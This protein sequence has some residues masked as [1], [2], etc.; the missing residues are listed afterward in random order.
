MKARREV[1]EKLV[2]SAVAKLRAAK[3]SGI[4]I[5]SRAAEGSAERVIIE[6]AERFGADLIVLGSHGHSAWDRLILGSTA[7]TV[8]LHAPCSV[9]IVRGKKKRSL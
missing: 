8:A 1:S 7:H 4:K 3:P 6:E 2:S 9:H 5:T